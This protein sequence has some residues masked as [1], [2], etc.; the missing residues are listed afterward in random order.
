MVKIGIFKAYDV[1]GI[2]PTELNEDTAYKVGRAFVSFLNCKKLIVGRDMRLSSE[3]LFEA[4]TKGI[5][6]QGADV[7]EVGL[8][9]TDMVYFATGFYRMDGGIMITA[10]HNPKEYNGFKFCREDAIAVGGDS[11]L[12]EIERLAEENKFAEPAN[13]GRI[14]KK[15]IIGDF[16]NRALSMV[17]VKK[18][19]PLKIVVDAGNGIGGL[20]V[21]KVM[22]KLPCKII[23]LYFELDGNFPNHLASPIE[24]E[25]L[26][27][28]I[29]RVKTEKADLGLAFDGDGD[30][31]FI[32]DDKGE[33]FTSSFMEA[34]ISRWVL[35]RYPGSEILYNV[36]SSWLVPD[37]IKE[38]GG[39]P[40][41]TP[42]GHAFIKKIMRERNAP[43]AGE[44]SGHYFFRDFYYAD[45]G[46]IAAL[47]MLE[48]ISTEGIAL[49]EIAKRYKRY[50]WIEE[51][52]FSVSDKAGKMAEIEAIHEDAKE[53]L[54]LDGISFIYDDWWFNVR[55]S[56]TE[57]LLRLNME[58]KTQEKLDK[59]KARLIKE[60]ESSGK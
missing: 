33:R 11:G 1:R 8:C 27:D 15:E 55:P 7:Y 21:P 14:I 22:D 20:V 28:L 18:I 3:R 53:I 24:I 6:D 26:R 9:S 4:L 45:S 29:A 13:K 16:V 50:F 46:I 2:Y 57:P 47:I 44:H 34:L 37:V 48:I 51:T 42:V 58:A 54:H 25:N 12:K 52:N 5:T 60:I 23:P 39:K 19:K 56:N 17:D 10:S 32:I 36:V 38:A 41:M 49:S 35:E 59:M 43:F 30:R 31:V 40:V